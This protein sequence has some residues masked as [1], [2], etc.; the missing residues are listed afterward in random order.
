MP[1]PAAD[2]RA[3]GTHGRHA[4]TVDLDDFLKASERVNGGSAQF[5]EEFRELLPSLTLESTH[6]EG[7]LGQGL[8]QYQEGVDVFT[9]HADLGLGYK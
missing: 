5:L 2:A 8:G 4:Q 6:Y 3:A 7:Q 1:K 9:G